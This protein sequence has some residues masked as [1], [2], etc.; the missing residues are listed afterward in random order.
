[1]REKAANP[2]ARA[3]SPA[4]RWRR[5]TPIEKNIRGARVRAAAAATH[6]RRRRGGGA[7]RE[8][9]EREAEEQACE[10]RHLFFTGCPL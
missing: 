8:R 10:R 5:S 9:D 2:M 3:L 4:A 7:R 6:A 1:M